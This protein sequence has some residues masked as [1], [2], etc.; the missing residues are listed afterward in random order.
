MTE[1]CA[2]CSVEVMDESDSIKCSGDCKGTLHFY[3]AGFSEKSLRLTEQRRLHWRCLKCQPAKTPLRNPSSTDHL[4]EVNMLT[5]KTTGPTTH[6]ALPKSHE[7]KSD[8]KSD[9]QFPD[10]YLELKQFISD[11][12]IQFAK[13][14]EFHGALVSDLTKSIDQL[15]QE[16][17]TIKSENA[18]IKRENA[19][20]KSEI[21]ELKLEVSELQQYSRRSNIEI[22]GIPEVEHE[23]VT[24]TVKKVLSCL[25]LN[26]EDKIV[27]AH[28]IPTSRRDRHK[29]IIVQFN[30]KNEKE[31]CLKAAKNK[32]LLASDL[33]ERFN[34]SP[35]YVNEHLA[36]AIK[37]LL[38]LSKSF[39]REN[40]FKF[41]WTKGGKI[42]LRKDENSKIF[43]IRQ[44]TDLSKI[45]A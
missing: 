23:N 16:I 18:D 36:P 1:K 11:Q 44:E 2:V 26:I 7:E 42:Y 12:F 17:N 39:K 15:K 21:S 31:E 40:N 5:E 3:C 19:Y 38:F 29:S 8:R 28:R 45:T 43:K 32:H 34:T 27:V 9:P 20:L 37:K 13:N 33:H 22:S 41:C 4:A 14:L 30:S 24:E 6:D 25:E 35:I 10:N